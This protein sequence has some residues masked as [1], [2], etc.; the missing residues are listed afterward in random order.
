MFSVYQPLTGVYIEDIICTTEKESLVQKPGIHSSLPIEQAIRLM[1][2]DRIELDVGKISR[3][4]PAMIRVVFFSAASVA[5]LYLKDDQAIRNKA[6]QVIRSLSGQK[7]QVSLPDLDKIAANPQ[8]RHGD[9]QILP[10]Q[11]DQAHLGRQPID[12]EGQQT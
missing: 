11:H 1:Q 7:L 6:K 9:R 3:L 5:G 4:K 10:G 12:H 8:S 2:T